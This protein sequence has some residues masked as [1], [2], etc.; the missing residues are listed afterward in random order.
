MGCVLALVILVLI[1]IINMVARSE[2][3]EY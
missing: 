2:N 3:Y 1:S